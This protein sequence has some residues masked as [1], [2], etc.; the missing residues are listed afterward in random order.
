MMFTIQKSLQYLCRCPLNLLSQEQ[1]KQYNSKQ[2]Q[3]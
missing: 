1:Q 2:K 3:H